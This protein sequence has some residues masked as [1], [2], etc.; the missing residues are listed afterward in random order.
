MSFGA[1]LKALREQKGWTQKELASRLS[2]SAPSV[3]AY[4]LEQKK[5]S[6]EMLLA[7]ADALNVSLDELCGRKPPVRCLADVMRRIVALDLEYDLCDGQIQFE[8][9]NGSTSAIV[10]HG[11]IIDC[12]EEGYGYKDSLEDIEEPFGPYP[13]MKNLLSVFLVGYIKMRDLLL[14]ENID[15]ETFD[16]WLSNQY[17]KNSSEIFHSED[18]E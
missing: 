7:L 4:E 13:V 14:N 10:F 18:D 5:P 3:I 11:W 16:L 6:Y 12:A 9:L 1:N 15:Q 17:K 8:I 2:L